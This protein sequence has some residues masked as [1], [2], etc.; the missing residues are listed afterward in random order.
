ME[1]I[2]NAIIRK[3]IKHVILMMRLGEFYTLEQVIE[4]IFKELAEQRVYIDNSHKEYIR[5]AVTEQL[6]YKLKKAN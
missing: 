2:I 5:Q 3:K 1:T 6:K 4:M